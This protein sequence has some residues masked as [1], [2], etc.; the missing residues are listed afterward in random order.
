[1][2][3]IALPHTGAAGPGPRWFALRAFGNEAGKGLRLMWRHRAITITSIVMNGLLYLMIQFS[4][5]AGTSCCRC[6]P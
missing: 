3:A 5:A 1:M 6:W 4:S 2:T